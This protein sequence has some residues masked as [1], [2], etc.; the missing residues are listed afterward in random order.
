MFCITHSPMS[1]GR[2]V[3]TCLNRRLGPC[4]DWQQYHRLAEHFNFI[5]QFPD[6][7][8]AKPQFVHC[9][10][11]WSRTDW[12]VE[13]TD[14]MLLRCTRSE[15]EQPLKLVPPPPLQPKMRHAASRTTTDLAK[16]FH[17]HKR[18]N[19]VLDDS[20][21]TFSALAQPARLVK[22]RPGALGP[23]PAAAFTLQDSLT[24]SP[25]SN[26][27]LE[28]SMKPSSMPGSQSGSAGSTATVQRDPPM[29]AGM[30]VQRGA[31]WIW[32]DQDRIEDG[33]CYGTV[34]EIVTWLSQPDGGIRV[35]W[36]NGHVDDYRFDFVPESGASLY[37]V[38]AVRIVAGS[39]VQRGLHWS[40][41]G[42][43]RDDTNQGM[44]TVLKLT[45]HGTWVVDW[46]GD[47]RSVYS[48]PCP[49][50]GIL[51]IESV[52]S[53][54]VREPVQPQPRVCLV[55]PPASRFAQRDVDFSRSATP[56]FT[57]SIR[58]NMLQMHDVAA[59][60]ISGLRLED[61]SEVHPLYIASDTFD[62]GVFCV[63]GGER[64]RKDEEFPWTNMLQRM[65]FVVMPEP[66]LPTDRSN[67]S[68]YRALHRLKCNGAMP[69]ADAS[70]HVRLSGFAQP[71]SVSETIGS[72]MPVVLPSDW[73][74][75][76][77]LI[78]GR[79]IELRGMVLTG[80]SKFSAVCG[81][82]YEVQASDGALRITNGGP[83]GATHQRTEY[84]H[85]MQRGVSG[86]DSFG[87]RTP[88]RF[89]LSTIWLPA[90]ACRL[91]PDQTMPAGTSCIVRHNS[92]NAFS[93]ARLLPLGGLLAAKYVPIMLPCFVS[94]SACVAAHHAVHL[95]ISV[96][97]PPRGSATW[98]TG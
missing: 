13:L 23:V 75:S 94:S 86:A 78:A 52:S 21:S 87:S 83:V 98:H 45:H 22:A 10:K 97:A 33:Y 16:Q 6:K 73:V 26:M 76:P 1:A 27:F 36:D 74:V 41:Q 68:E 93:P 57:S 85:S 56:R 65:Q 53:N 49:L 61:V 55:N 88:P 29:Q 24:A 92:S 3:W 50:S 44:G 31:D 81:W 43:D 15:G 39:R 77:L 67:L 32:G 25:A 84:N 37:D 18:D 4:A 34:D 38:K 71:Q 11:G 70:L 28:S 82:L 20:P 17:R 54:E 95:K 51:E 12:F 80:R 7:T 64:S 46:D 91:L 59:S 72:D 63:Q 66:H 2:A 79:Q 48:A 69:T 19:A 9:L 30:R 35:R 40:D 5:K 90:R 58:A 47:R 60:L 89:S 8:I 96:Q 14:A 42:R 62:R